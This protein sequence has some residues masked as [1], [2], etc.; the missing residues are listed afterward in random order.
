MLKLPN[1]GA[2]RRQNQVSRNR[3]RIII[4]RN[5][6]TAIGRCLSPEEWQRLRQGVRR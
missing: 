5:G 3:E 4:H 1:T 2:G 6:L